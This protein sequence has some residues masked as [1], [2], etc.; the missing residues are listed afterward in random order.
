MTENPGLASSNLAIGSNHASR[1]PER[2]AWGLLAL[3]VLLL[4]FVLP[5]DIEGDGRL[6][7][8]AIQS[9]L[10]G[11]GVPDTKYP[12]I[13]SIPSIPLF[14]LGRVV[15]SPEWWV[16]RYNVIVYAAG[17]VLS[18]RLLR[19]RLDPEILLAFLLLLGTTAM[20]PGSLTGFGAEPFTL[21][22]I[23][24]GLAAWSS[25]RWKTATA[26]LALGV[27][28]VPASIVGVA[29]AMGWWAWRV[30]QVRAL[31]PVVVGAG[32]WLLENL[33]R[34]KSALTTG[35]EGDHGFR[36]LLPYS[37]LLG[38]SYP[39]FFGVLSLLASFGKGLLFFASGLLLA[40][41]RGLVTL[42][43]VSE[44]LVLWCLY[45]AG[46]VVAYGSWWAW[47]GGFTW[48]PRFLIFASLPATL[49]LAAQVRRPPQ[50]LIALTVVIAALVLSVWVGIDGQVFGRF[51]QDPC[52]ANHYSLESLC[53]YVPEFSV[54]WTPFVFGAQVPWWGFVLV[55]YAV[56][57]ST[58][59]ALPLIRDWASA[60]YRDATLAWSA[61]RRRPS[62]RL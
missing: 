43:S 30:K 52:S 48:G 22:A 49:L 25:G 15:G 62:W 33:V 51:G 39:I 37:G 53:W 45:L 29:L 5:H 54:L 38:F 8:D 41:G 27:A 16:S 10:A 13:G 34:R 20:I 47:Y 44:T 46:L 50:R 23:A 40:F 3:G 18:Y 36:T 60:I 58:Y 21:M 35:Y 42:R 2:I 11:G 19:D 32:L 28:N 4:F 1:I 9:L 12:L 31:A 14:L 59:V 57:V 55:A 61:Y 24:T 7:F 6:R 26:L 17:L 56:G